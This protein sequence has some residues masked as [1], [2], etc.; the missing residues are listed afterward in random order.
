MSGA[1]LLKRTMMR[2][3][4]N[5]II[6]YMIIA[7]IAYYIL[8]IVVP[9]LIWGVIIWGVFKAWMEYQKHK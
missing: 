4:E 5:K 3:N 7:I 6:G 9:F 2:E 1:L 8:E